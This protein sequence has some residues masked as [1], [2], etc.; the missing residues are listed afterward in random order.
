VDYESKAQDNGELRNVRAAHWEK[1]RRPFQSAKNFQHYD[2]GA[3][4]R[5]NRVH[6]GNPPTDLTER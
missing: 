2:Y 5:K 1:P 3:S 4:Q 6:K